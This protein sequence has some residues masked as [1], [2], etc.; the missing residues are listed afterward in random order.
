M[1]PCTLASAARVPASMAAV[2]S[3]A[4][5][6]S[7]QTMLSAWRAWPARQQLLAT[8]ATPS[9]ICTTSI[10]P[11]MALAL[12]ASKDLTVPPMTSHCANEA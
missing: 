6:P 3:A 2:F 11:G 10:T 9:E 5:G 12:A 7:S 4:P 1:P 8:T